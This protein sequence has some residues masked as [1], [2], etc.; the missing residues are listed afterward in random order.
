M[1]DAL[2]GIDAQCSRA[3]VRHAGKYFARLLHAIETRQL[4]V[5][6]DDIWR[7]WRDR[8]VQSMIA[9][10]YRASEL[11]RAN[12]ARTRVEM[13]D[14]IGVALRAMNKRQRDAVNFYYGKI[15][16]SVTHSTRARVR[17]KLLGDLRNRL[18]GPYPGRRKAAREMLR[19]VGVHKQQQSLINTVTRTQNSV[20]FNAAVWNEALQ[21]EDLWGFEYTTAGDERVR[22]TH[23]PF[24]GV[25]YPVRHPF[26]RQYAPPNGW[27]CRCTLNPIYVGDRDASVLEYRGTPE[28]PREFRFNP[29]G[30]FSLS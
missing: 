26:W 23:V 30:I 17:D 9:T 22:A 10:H 25:R 20:A 15:A 2:Q 24:D 5:R 14:P 28:V 6:D 19:G 7:E 12:R 18:R 3:L 4:D 11:Y 29:G 16:T 1:A 13:A 21:D 8:L 27:N